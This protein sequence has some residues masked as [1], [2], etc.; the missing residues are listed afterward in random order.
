MKQILNMK[1]VRIATGSGTKY[2]NQNNEL[3]NLTNEIQ[4]DASVFNGPRCVK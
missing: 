3:T 1:E 2:A 4:Q